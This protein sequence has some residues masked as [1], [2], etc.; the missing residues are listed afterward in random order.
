MKPLLCAV[1]L[2]ALAACAARAGAPADPSGN[3]IAA[4]GNVEVAIRPCGAELCGDVVRVM[5]NNS[6]EGPGAAPTPPA[7]VGLRIFS[8]LRPDGDGWTGHIFNREQNRTY[9][10]HI[11]VGDGGSLTV[12]AYI[13]APLIGKTQIWRR[14]EG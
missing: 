8:D 10:C 11:A 9:D 5:A 2:L 13:G 14:A 6:M 4:S 7:Q 1:A 3:W 12:R